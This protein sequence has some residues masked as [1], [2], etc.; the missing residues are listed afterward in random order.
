M[1]IANW[2]KPL[3]GFTIS[4]ISRA[5]GRDVSVAIHDCGVSTTSQTRPVCKHSLSALQVYK[6]SPVETQIGL[7][8]CS[9]CSSSYWVW[10]KCERPLGAGLRSVNPA[11]EVLREY[12]ALAGFSRHLS[13]GFAHLN[14]ALRGILLQNILFVL[15]GVLNKEL[16]N[17]SE[18]LKV[19]KSSLNI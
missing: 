17:I 4:W 16:A 6:T 5:G 1:S 13:A 8:W 10:D 15:Q 12:K 2:P 18:W 7:L 14:P 3:G 11:L 19:N 9:F